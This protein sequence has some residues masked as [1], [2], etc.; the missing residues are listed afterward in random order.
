MPAASVGNN[1]RINMYTVTAVWQ[2]CEI[3]FG[4]GEGFGY[5]VSE[6]L[7]SI[8]GFYRPVL[9]EVTLEIR[10]EGGMKVTAPASLYA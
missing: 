9:D 2:D 1:G 6:A 8:D 4:E 3:G 10:Q 5:A 7:D